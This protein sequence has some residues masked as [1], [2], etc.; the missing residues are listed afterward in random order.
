MNGGCTRS[1]HGTLA[2]RDERAIVTRSG[3]QTSANDD[4]V[5]RALLTREGARLVVLA[6]ETRSLEHFFDFASVALALRPQR[7]PV[8]FEQHAGRVGVVGPGAGGRPDAPSRV[9]QWHPVADEARLCALEPEPPVR[10]TWAKVLGAHRRERR[11]PSSAATVA[12]PG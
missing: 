11:R 9:E 4:L 7:Y 5:A 2:R 8:L 3:Y 1:R 10:G 12:L 6:R